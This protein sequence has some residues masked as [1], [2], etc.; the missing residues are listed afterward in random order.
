[1]PDI[2]RRLTEPETTDRITGDQLRDIATVLHLAETGALDEDEPKVCIP[3]WLLPTLKQALRSAYQQASAGK[4]RTARADRAWRAAHTRVRRYQRVL[5][6]THPLDGGAALSKAAA[7]RVVEYEEVQVFDEPPPG[8]RRRTRQTLYAKYTGARVKRD[9]WHLER[10][11]SHAKLQRLIDAR[12]DAAALRW[13]AFAPS[14]LN[15]EQVDSG[16]AAVELAIR[17]ER[18]SARKRG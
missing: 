8:G 18:E 12:A 11:H 10:T 6:L 7:F 16:K 9:Y 5:D 3:T 1:M 13:L 4:G 15:G 14:S 17:H 2:T